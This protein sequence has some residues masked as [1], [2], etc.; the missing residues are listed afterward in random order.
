MDAFALINHLLS[1]I[2]PALF[3][4]LVLALASL[5]W[6]GLPRGEG[7]NGAIARFWR[8]LLCNALVGSAVLVAS[9]VAFGHDGEIAG[10]AL[11]VLAVASC[12]WLLARGWR[13][14]GP[15]SRSS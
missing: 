8:S 9:L 6:P 14:A 13:R 15:E 7:G 1:F 12:Q 11:L 2:A 4:A 3:I 10:Y 5:F